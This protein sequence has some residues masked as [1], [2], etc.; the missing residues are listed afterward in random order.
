MYVP[1]HFL[2]YIPNADILPRPPLSLLQTYYDSTVRHTYPN[3]VPGCSDDW[4][5]EHMLPEGAHNHALDWTVMFLNRDKT[6]LDEDWPSR[7][8]ERA[9]A[10]AVSGG[11]EVSFFK[12]SVVAG[13][14]VSS[15]SWLSSL[16]W[17]ACRV[18]TDRGGLPACRVTPPP[19]EKKQE[20]TRKEKQT[21]KSKEKARRK[22]REKATKAKQLKQEKARSKNPRKNIESKTILTAETAKRHVS[23]RI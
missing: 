10:R 9:G 15:P 20:E 17:T 7:F 16:L 2:P 4:F 21:R 22:I 5:A 11:V 14:T 13:V 1:K 23:R 18:R 8:D 19:K 6:A 12:L 3:T